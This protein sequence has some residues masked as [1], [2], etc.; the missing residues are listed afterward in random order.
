[1]LRIQL[2]ILDP[3]LG[4]EFPLPDYATAGAAAMDLRAMT[5]SDFVLK[6]GEVKMVPA[7]FAIYIRDPDIVGVIC[8]R[9]GLGAK[10]GIVL[11]NLT[12]IIDS[13]YQGPIMFPLWN[14]APAK[15]KIRAGD[16]VAQMLFL[17]VLKAHFEICEKFEATARGHGGFGST[18][19]D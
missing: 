2:K 10:H 1:M 3:R 5:P 6:P 19:I 18:G 9:S 16:R 15:F 12:G 13:D 4:R 17:P 7:G 8:P 14:H 11:S